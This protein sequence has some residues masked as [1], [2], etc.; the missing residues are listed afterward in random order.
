LETRSKISVIS[1]SLC[2]PIAHNTLIVVD[3]E[4]RGQSTAQ[5]SSSHNL[6]IHPIIIHHQV[7]T[8]RLRK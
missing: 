2:T 7:A 3:I 6:V 5:P 1:A 8:E 4:S